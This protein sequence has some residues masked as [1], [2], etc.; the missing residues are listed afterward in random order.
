[1]KVKSINYKFIRRTASKLFETITIP[2]LKK[3]SFK[4]TDKQTQNSRLAHKRL[5]TSRHSAYL[6]F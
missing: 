4:N 1:M 2:C 6:C 5:K 3:S